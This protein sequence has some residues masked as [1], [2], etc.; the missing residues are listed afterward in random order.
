MRRG[1]TGFHYA[2]RGGGKGEAL[3]TVNYRKLNVN[4]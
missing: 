2:I 4:Y 1:E 3:I